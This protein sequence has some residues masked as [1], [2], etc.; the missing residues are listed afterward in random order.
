VIAPVES[1]L[2]ARD[3]GIRRLLPEASPVPGPPASRPMGPAHGS[4]PWVRP[5][6]LDNLSGQICLGNPVWAIL[7][8]KR[9]NQGQ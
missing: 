3:S 8:G 1:Q 6:G 5:I 7:S 9:Q 2:G 4:G